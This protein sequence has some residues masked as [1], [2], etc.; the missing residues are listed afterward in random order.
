[1]AGRS[2]YTCT[3][4]A[5]PRSYAQALVF[6]PQG[7]LYVPITAGAD[8]GQLRVYDFSA[9]PTAPAPYEAFQFSDSNSHPIASPWT[10][11]WYLAFDK[12]DPTTLAYRP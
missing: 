4:Q 6:G 10:S 8:A 12:T 11:P 3:P 2:L 1:M 7:R 9:G 5:C